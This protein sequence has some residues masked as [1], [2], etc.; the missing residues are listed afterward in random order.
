MTKKY[1]YVGADG[2]YTE[3]LAYET[4]DH[5][6]LSAGVGDAGKPIVLDSRGKFDPSFYV[7]G[8]IDHNQLNN[9]AVG[10]VHTQYILVA[11]TRAFTGNQSFGGFKATN[12]ADP[13][14]SGDAVSLG[15]LS[16][17]AN[18]KGASQVGVEDAANYFAGTT[19]EAV[20]AELYNLVGMDG[21]SYTADTGGVTKGDLLYISANNKVKPF[22]PITTGKRAVGLAASTVAAAGSVFAVENGKV[23]TGTLTGATFGTPYYWTGS[24]YTT[25]LSTTP[26][27]YVWQV[28]VAKNATDLTIEV[29]FIHKVA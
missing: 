21:T 14:A 16:S 28:G 13:T 8:D 3:S 25:A 1:L 7:F 17:V 23:L 12:L 20:L 2:L 27:D 9:L 10:D 5:I 26:G 24:A 15:F 29:L 22:S 19:V 6:A 18:G 11:G 4:I